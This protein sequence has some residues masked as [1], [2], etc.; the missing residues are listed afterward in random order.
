MKA[1]IPKE[2]TAGETR[3]AATPETVKKLRAAGLAVAIE[4]GAGLGAHFTDEAYREAGAEIVEH[5]TAL[6]AEI[7]FKI[8]KPTP[9]EIRHL[10]SGAVLIS[11]LDMCHDD[12]TFDL[13]AAQGVDSFALEM[14][15]RLSRAQTMDVLSSQA[16]IAGYRAVL[17]AARLYGRFFP[18][19]MTSAGSAKPARVVVLGAGVAGLQA[20]ATAR[21]LG[22]QVWAYDVRP[23]VKEQIQSLG[24]K[25]IEFDLDESGAGSGGY[26]KALS[27]EAQK[28]QQQL[29]QE[30]L[31]KADIIVS[32]ALIPCMS[33]PLLITEE[34]VK[35]MHEG[36]VIVDLAAAS[37]GNCPLTEA[38]QVVVKHGVILCGYTNFPA[39]MPS[40][41]SN[42]FAR[43]VYNF[44]MQM[45][46]P[47]NGALRFKDH[48]ADE[49]TSKTLIT[50]QGKVRFETTRKEKEK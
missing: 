47:S 34:T 31:K 22:A 8:H 23:E 20:I 38:D 4:T 40:D 7:V 49:I 17:E 3:V 2:Y 11:L 30:E 33:A 46:D 35:G 44:L 29:L 6:G 5:K 27:P 45:L 32:T 43:N 13:L 42:F 12:G 39:L 26:A 15:P 14:M 25:F 21:R 1:G 10:K 41:A 36:A 16:N 48:F 24:A 18:M 19:M 37:G 50:H 9:E 28:K